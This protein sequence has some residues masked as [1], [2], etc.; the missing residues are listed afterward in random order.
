MLSR[1]VLLTRRTSALAASTWCWLQGR[2][3]VR[4]ALHSAAPGKEEECYQGLFCW[5]GGQV[6]LQ[7]QLEA[8]HRKDLAW[9]Q[10]HTA[11]LLIQKIG[12]WSRPVLLTRRTSSPAA[13]TWCWPQGR[14][15]PWGQDHTALLMIQQVGIL[16]RPDLL[17]R[18][19][20]PPAASTWCWPWGRSDMRPASEGAAPDI[21]SR[22]VIEAWFSHKEDKSSC[23]LHL[24]LTTGK[25]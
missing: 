17:T 7:P 2:Y 3:G 21:E 15:Y 9:G 8:D 22:N 18:R 5:Q 13:S 20:S 16:S 11:T 24:M 4:P 23:G 19:T 12:M 25:I 14:F 1:P 10:H 6:L